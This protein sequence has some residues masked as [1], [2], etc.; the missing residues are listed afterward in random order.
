MDTACPLPA[1]NYDGVVSRL[2]LLPLH[3][4]DNVNHSLPLHR[5]SDLRPAVEVEVTDVSRLLLLDT[6]REHMS[7]NHRMGLK[8]P[9]NGHR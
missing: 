5:Y 2:L 9:Q 8:T 3:G 1:V 7:L 6:D 4:S